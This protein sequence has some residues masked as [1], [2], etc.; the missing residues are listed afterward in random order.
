LAKK[1]LTNLCLKNWQGWH[2]T[3]SV[4]PVQEIMPVRNFILIQLA[5]VSLGTTPPAPTR[6]DLTAVG[7]EHIRVSLTKPLSLAPEPYIAHI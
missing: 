1:L 6:K 4:P 2:N 3:S 7:V 5:S